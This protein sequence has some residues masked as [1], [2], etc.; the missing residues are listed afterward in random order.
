[1]I[2]HKCSLGEIYFDEKF[3]LVKAAKK[4]KP[5]DKEQTKKILEKLKERAKEFYEPNLQITKQKIREDVNEDNLIIQAINNIEEVK[6]VANTLEKRVREWYELYNP[7]LSKKI[8]DHEKFVKKILE[9]DVKKEKNTM[10]AELSKEDTEPIKK[11][12]KELDGLYRF[13]EEQTDY[14]AEVMKKYCP[15]MQEIAGTLIGAKL[16]NQ[17]R[18]LRKLSAMPSSTLQL[19]GAERAL[20]RHMQTHAK[21]PKYGVIV[22]HAYVMA[23]SRAKKGKAARTLANKLSIAVRVDYN[24]GEYIAD[25]LKKQL[26]STNLK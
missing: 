15:N 23:A 24:K 20:F 26:E 5:A 4:A 9:G 25:K 16:I 14:L 12:A 22:N 7:E 17:A 21:P 18:S 2:V 10:G 3:N 8:T 6:R 1:M 19:L 11:L 13:R